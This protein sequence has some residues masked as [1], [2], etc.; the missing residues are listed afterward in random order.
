[1]DL[2]CFVGAADLMERIREID[3]HA[4]E[5]RIERRDI[6]L[7]VICLDRH[8]KFWYP[9]TAGFSPREHYDKQEMQRTES[10][11]RAFELKLFE[12]GQEAQQTSIQI[13]QDSKAVVSD[14]KSIAEKNDHFTRRVTLLVIL[15]AIIQAVGQLL[16]LP[17]VPWVQRVWHHFFR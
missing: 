15:L 10:D 6:A 5:R 7:E 16:A 13:A 12:L 14:L 11:R 9:Y 2:V 1:M 4:D 17:S 3:W 8:C